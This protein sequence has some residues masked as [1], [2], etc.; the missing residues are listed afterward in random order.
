MNRPDNIDELVSKLQAKRDLEYLP[1]IDTQVDKSISETI[2]KF[3]NN[4]VITE[5]CCSGILQEHYTLDSLKENI[6]YENCDDILI[7]PFVHTKATFHKKINDKYQYSEEYYLISR[8]LT[9]VSVYHNNKNFNV[10]ITLDYMH[11]SE[12]SEETSVYLF[13]IEQPELIQIRKKCNNYKEYDFVIKK[14][15]DKLGEI[16][17][18]NIVN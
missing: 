11:K 7:E 8:D 16:I 4:N 13:Y 3:N 1:C 5:S 10:R 17:D 6:P 18:E 12:D 9:R 2:K 15:V 14:Y